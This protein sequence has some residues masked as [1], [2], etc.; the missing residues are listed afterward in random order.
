M[1]RRKFLA[2]TS[3]SIVGLAG[4][5]GFEQG[6]NPV[7]DQQDTPE[8]D[9]DAPEE[10]E[11][12]TRLGLRDVGFDGKELVVT[13]SDAM[14]VTDHVEIESETGQGTTIQL[15]GNEGRKEIIDPRRAGRPDVRPIGP[16]EVTVLL[17]DGEG[18][19]VGEGTF[20]YDPNLVL[21]VRSASGSVYQQ[22]EDPK[23]SA[24]F[25]FSNSGTGPTYLKSFE[26]RDAE[27]TLPLTEP[28]DYGEEETTMVRT[29]EVSGRD[30]ELFDPVGI[31]GD[32]E[33][34]FLPQGAPL[35]FGGD[36]IFSYTGPEPEPTE[37]FTQVF[38]VVAKT[39]LNREFI[40]EV[41]VEFSG[42]ITEASMETA[43]DS[44]VYCFEEFE[45][46]VEQ[47]GSP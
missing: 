14:N 5:S 31:D 30:S 12:P 34:L 41:T 35:S 16:G 17:Y 15:S 2:L 36:G 11:T 19:V 24:L 44:K 39:E 1:D 37:T 25:T 13:V 46:S 3:G 47:V 18:E 42:G 45:A 32:N 23:A 33:D 40:F 20:E 7:R 10:A 27:N 22:A 26:V 29:G 6:E 38:E 4:C 8:S 9:N 28:D 43:S 21:N